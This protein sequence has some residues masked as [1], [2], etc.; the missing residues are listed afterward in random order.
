MN[1]KHMQILQLIAEGSMVEYI[2]QL[3]LDKSN[4]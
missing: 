3:S 1:W 2:L 4:L